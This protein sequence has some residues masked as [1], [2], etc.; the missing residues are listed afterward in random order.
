MISAMGSM[1]EGRLAELLARRALDQAAAA[2]LGAYAAE[3]NG[4]LIHVMGDSQAAND[5]LSQVI[6]DFWR[7]LGSFHNRCTVR[8]WLYTL[9][10][11]A[12]ARYRRSPWHRQ[13]TGDAQLEG[14]VAAAR[15]QTPPWQRTAVKD[16]WRELRDALDPDDRALLVLRVDRGL[17][18]IDVARVMLCERAPD[19]CDAELARET[20]RL[21]KRFQLLKRELRKRAREVGLAEEA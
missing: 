12:V 11:H 7:G 6:E 17:E 10:R 8:T 13:R 20:V 4:F 14:L 19:P 21:R 9:A 15:S 1:V 3:L 16:R 5:V 2:A 18:W